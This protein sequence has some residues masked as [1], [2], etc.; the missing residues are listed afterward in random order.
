M[1]QTVENGINNLNI[2]TDLYKQ[3]KSKITSYGGKDVKEPV[4]AGKDVGYKYVH[5]ENKGYGKNSAMD[6]FNDYLQYQQE[7]AKEAGTDEAAER[8]A[9]KEAEKEIARSLSSEEIKKLEMMGIDVEGANLSDIMGM[10][11]TMRGEAHRQELKEMMAK[12]AA[13]NGDMENLTLVGGSVKV[14][15]S[16]VKLDSVSV[17][18]VVADE[19]AGDIKQEFQQSNAADFNLGN[20]QLIYLIKNNLDITK[21]NIY[22]AQFSGSKSQ[23]DSSAEQLVEQMLPQISKVVE[24]AGFEGNRDAVEGAK[25]LIG[26]GLPVTPDTVKKYMEYQQYVGK[27]MS[28]VQMP[29]GEPEVI[30]QKTAELYQDVKNIDPVLAYDMAAKD[31]TITIA[32]V[33]AYGKDKNI[34]LPYI[35]REDILQY[36]LDNMP[37]DI[38]EYELKSIRAMRQME[39]IRLSMTMDVAA[40][41]I[42]EDINIDIRELSK[43]VDK[44]KNMERQMISGKLKD[45]GVEPTEENVSLYKEVNYK[46]NQIKMAPA[47]VIAAPVK[48]KAFTVNSLYAEAK[49][50]EAKKS[51]ESVWTAPRADMGDSIKKAFA[52]VDDILI[53]LNFDVNAESQRAVRILGYNS[54]D[55]TV[56]NINQVMNYDRQVNQLINSFYP[57]AVLSMIKEG[58]NPLD[59]SIEELNKVIQ[60]KNYNAGVTEAKN[61]A[62]Y[63]M[64][65]EK[66]GE[67][68]DAERESYIGIYR[69]MHQLAKSG[70]REAGWVFANG[71]NLTVRNLISAMRSKKAA[72]FDISIDDN[73]GMLAE[74]TKIGKDMEQQIETAFNMRTLA[75]ISKEAEEFALENNIEISYV[76][77]TA[78]NAML[79][80]EGGIYQLVSDILS[81]MKF[82]SHSKEK[83][84]DEETEKITDSLTGDDAPV[85]FS[86]ASILES[87]K[88]SDVMSLKYEDLRDRLTELMYMAGAEGSI[89]GMDISAIKTANA[90]F[91]ILS[92]MAKNDKYQVPVETEQGVKVMNLTVVHDASRKGTIEFSIEGNSMGKVTGNIRLRIAESAFESNGKNSD[93]L[94][95]RVMLEG[96]I[97]SSE[98]QGNYMLM[99]EKDLFADKLAQYGFDPVDINMGSISSFTEEKTAENIEPEYIYT[100][101]V[102]VVKAMGV[103]IS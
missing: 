95:S 11:N 83:A 22:K 93:N 18:D 43:V 60:D 73:F 19:I 71:S 79:T 90:G 56:D 20:D 102:S 14:A 16:D 98:S 47:D 69:V 32:S 81:K 58:I 84:V 37:E 49:F 63:L 25:L 54:L 4:D 55:I 89:T 72:G 6:N 64:D 31:K 12:V 91:N 45:N 2:A 33:V 10:V 59:V 52:N 51:Y 85:E 97:V 68:T 53:D 28:Q 34:K 92:K 48:G 26:N 78:I 8:R 88:N 1:G 96:Y 94:S 17:S 36:D 38:P 23:A 87:L 65:M 7:K 44:L 100:A 77:T 80:T 99:E 86:P 62:T 30:E 74:T 40:R 41:L 39:E 75:N 66:M 70:D 50:A 13:N 21:E 76:N 46:I 24:Q 67:I 27:D 9:A 103:I 35:N 3:D 82:T 42:K 15:G 29:E 101:A 5:E 61:F 57:E